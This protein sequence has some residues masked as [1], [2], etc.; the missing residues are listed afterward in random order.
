MSGMQPPMFGS[1]ILCDY[2]HWLDTNR[3]QNYVV[4]VN[5]PLHCKSEIRVPG[6]RPSEPEFAA[7]FPMNFPVNFPGAV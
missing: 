5:P 3:W 2:S 6:Q 7:V 1:Y 4:I